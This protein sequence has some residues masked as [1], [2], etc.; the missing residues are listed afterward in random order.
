[1]DA[2]YV[3]IVDDDGDMREL[4]GQCVSAAGFEVKLAGDGAEAI[5]LLEHGHRPMAI[6][7]DLVMPHVTGLELLQHVR[8]AAS[9]TSIPVVIVTGTPQG[10]PADVFVITKP[11][12]VASLLRF[13]RDSSNN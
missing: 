10:L 1:M 13:L 3:L 2:K 5:A 12:Q 8:A 11:V 7:T 6:V 4:L 9:L